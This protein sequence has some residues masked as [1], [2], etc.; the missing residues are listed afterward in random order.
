LTFEVSLEH[1]FGDEVVHLTALRQVRFVL[2]S[3]DALTVF[4]AALAEQAH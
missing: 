2:F 3:A 4:E 1:L